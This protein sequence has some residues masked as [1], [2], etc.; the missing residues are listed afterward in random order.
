MHSSN[1]L[2]WIQYRCQ[3]KGSCRLFLCGP[4]CIERVTLR[5]TSMHTDLNN[6]RVADSGWFP[7]N[8]IWGL[9]FNSHRYLVTSSS[10][11]PARG[12]SLD[13]KP[14]TVSWSRQFWYISKKPAWVAMTPI[15]YFLF[16]NTNYLRVG[17]LLDMVLGTWGCYPLVVV[18]DLDW[19]P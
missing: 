15:W 7:L 19:T 12:T 8:M 17:F 5:A 10:W 11:I 4:Q 13:A 14:S 18:W 1:P 2:Y 16:V 9:F 3:G 6:W